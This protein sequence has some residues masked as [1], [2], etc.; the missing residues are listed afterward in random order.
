MST[1]G[2]TLPEAAA[3]VVRRPGARALVAGDDFGGAP[4][5]GEILISTDDVLDYARWLDQRV[6]RF[7][8]ESATGIASPDR[9][10]NLTPEQLGSFL[11]LGE[12]VTRWKA[13]LASLESSLWARVNAW[14]RVRAW[15]GELL[16]WSRVLSAKGFGPFSAIGAQ[17][18]AHPVT[19]AIGDA[20]K[21]PIDA[22]D[23]EINKAMVLGVCGLVAYGVLTKRAR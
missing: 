15:H 16:E 2:L 8:Q 14:D 17:P 9:V 21:G 20:V 18:S 13:F 3:R 4:H 19:D 12:W 10:S 23:R 6:A 1:Y 5:D 7:A 11:R 22:M